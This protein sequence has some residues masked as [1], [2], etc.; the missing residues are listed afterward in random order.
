[1]ARCIGAMAMVLRDVAMRV[2][3]LGRARVEVMVMVAVTA[4]VIVIVGFM[5]VTRDS[6]AMSMCMSTLI[7]SVPTVPGVVVNLGLRHELSFSW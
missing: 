5:S 6:G 2:W 1:M 7:W 3:M 4:T